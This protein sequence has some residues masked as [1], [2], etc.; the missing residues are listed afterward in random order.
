MSRASTFIAVTGLALASACASTSTTSTTT[1]ST[2]IGTTKAAASKS[3]TTASADT[4][5][6]FVWFDLITD[7]LP[8]VRKFYGTLLGWEFTDVTRFGQPYVLARNYGRLVGGFVPVAPAPKQEVSQWIGYQSV[9][10]VD[11]A[12]TAVGKSGGRTLVAPVDLNGVGRAAVVADTQGAPFGLLRLKGGDP[13]DEPAP[14]DGSFFW[15][16]YLARDPNAAAGFYTRT[17]GYER[18]VTDRLGMSEYIV[19]S[20]GRARAGV[21]QAPKPEMRPTWL[22]YVMVTDPSDL[23]T[24][25]SSLGGTVLLEPRADVRRGSLAVVMDPSGAIVAFQRYPF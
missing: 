21:L 19:L 11:D 15:M 1:T 14:T 5:G 24:K 17:F 4:I 12:V 13:A 6:K 16:E 23:I 10:N 22:P 8:A 3:A 25:V 2:T 9:E 20:R 18:S 7:D